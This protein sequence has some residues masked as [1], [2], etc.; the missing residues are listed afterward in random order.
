M[1]YASFIPNKFHI[2]MVRLKSISLKKGL[3]R[4]LRKK[5]KWRESMWKQIYQKLQT[6]NEILPKTLRHI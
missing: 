4:Q 2:F 3:L 1:S 5:M 6:Y